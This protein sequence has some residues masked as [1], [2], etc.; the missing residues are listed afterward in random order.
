MVQDG[1]RYLWCQSEGNRAIAIWATDRL[2]SLGERHVVWRAP[3]SGPYSREVWA[4]ELHKIGGR[5]HIYFAASDGRNENHLAYVLK[6]ETADPLGAYT[7]HGPLYTGDDPAGKDGNVWAIDMTPL[8]HGGQLYA[9]WSGWDAPGTD[10]QFLYIAPMRD[11]TATAG[12]RVRLCAND[13]YLWER[14]EERDGS[15]G[16]NEGPQILKHGGRTFVTYSCAASWLPTYKLGLLELTGDDPLDPASWKKYPEPIFQSTA[17][18][19]G[20]GHSCFVKSPDGRED[21]HVYHA[22][23]DRDPGWRRA[24]FIQPFTWRA[25]GL[26][27]FG[28]PVAP[29]SALPRPSG[30]MPASAPALPFE[31]SLQDG[32]QGWSYYGHHQ[33]LAEGEDGVHLG[34]VPDAPIND[35]RCG[36]KLVLDGLDVADVEVGVTIRVLDGERGNGLLFR[37]SAPSVG[38]DA[39]RGYFAGIIPTDQCV[40]LGRMDGERWQEL[41]R[42]DAKIERGRDYRLH[43]Q[44]RGPQIEV[45]LD[46]KA[47]LSHRDAAHSRGSVGIR[48]VRSHAVFSD[49]R[50][51]GL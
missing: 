41:A 42:A 10:R 39:H 34:I 7:L 21:W 5:W 44:A 4:P 1:A 2:T 20:V 38:Y 32:L 19:Y 27:D 46:G 33:F 29:G 13:D 22:K 48:V 45:S 36:E 18:T 23:R 24:I 14:T 43:V 3:R 15:R 49:F 12:P 11:G 8:D 37:A 47:L 16:L 35:Y 50:C 40:I 28:T 31:C 17:A 25:D 51:V 9:L 26:P 30:E 6:S